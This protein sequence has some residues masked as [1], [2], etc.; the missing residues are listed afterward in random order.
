MEEDGTLSDESTISAL[1]ADSFTAVQTSYDSAST[2]SSF[3]RTRNLILP[4]PH[5]VVFDTHQTQAQYMLLVARVVE[6]SVNIIIRGMF[7]KGNNNT[8]VTVMILK[9]DTIKSSYLVD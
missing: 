3:P 6:Q 2:P 1:T 9:D 5:R 8:R 4:L 7:S